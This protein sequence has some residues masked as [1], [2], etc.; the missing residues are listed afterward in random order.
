MNNKL[1]ELTDKI[2]L[3]GVEKGKN[4]AKEIISKASEDAEKIIA[5]AKSEAEKILADAEKQAKELE[6]NTKSELKLYT[7]QSLNALKSEITNII[8]EKVASIAVNSA[9]NDKQFMQSIISDIASKW[10]SNGEVVIEAKDAKSL[11]DY[12]MANAKELLNKCV[13]IKEV[14]G[15]KTDFTISPVNNGYKVAFG[16][17][18]FIEYFKDFLRPK[19]VDMLFN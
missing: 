7:D 9:L 11:E 13:T 1:Q 4:E 2:Y 6:K 10:I 19:L 17:N 8:S 16:E 15:L 18:E 3:E 5:Q 14:K 12:F